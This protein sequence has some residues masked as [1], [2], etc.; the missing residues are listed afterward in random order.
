LLSRLLVRELSILKNYC[1]NNNKS[2]N[3][4]TKKGNDNYH[5]I[6][7]AWHGILLLG[8]NEDEL[9]TRKEMILDKKMIWKD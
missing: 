4:S 6:I 3:N 9:K 2:D 8:S 1:N 5:N 7:K